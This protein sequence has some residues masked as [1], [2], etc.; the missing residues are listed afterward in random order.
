LDGNLEKNH[1]DGNVQHTQADQMGEVP[2]L[3][4]SFPFSNL[5]DGKGKQR[6]AAYEKSKE[7]QLDRF[8]AMDEF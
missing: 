1:A 3:N 8:D 2:Y 7:I 5:D 4:F 6:Q